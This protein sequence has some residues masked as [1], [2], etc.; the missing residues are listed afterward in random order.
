M[1]SIKSRLS[2]RQNLWSQKTPVNLA[3]TFITWITTTA[4][5]LY[6]IC[7]LTVMILNLTST[8][9]Y[10]QDNSDTPHNDSFN[11]IT[12][13]NQEDSFPES[14]D[15]NDWGAVM[16]ID[17]SE[18]NDV[19]SHAA[20]QH[21][22]VSWERFMV[23]AHEKSPGSIFPCTITSRIMSLLAFCGILRR[24]IGPG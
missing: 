2:D 5:I 13:E 3:K 9:D 10:P 1:F 6:N 22:T 12:L 20:V 24:R 23:W 21:F 8:E 7:L 15:G 4:Q 11:N 16:E 17:D 19:W 14:S 18:N